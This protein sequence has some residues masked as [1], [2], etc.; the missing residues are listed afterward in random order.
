LIF[1]FL[2]EFV[3]QLI[4]FFGYGGIFLLMLLESTATPVA[5]ELV[6]PFAGFLAGQGKFSLE[7][8]VL[9]GAFGSLVGSLISY[10][11][12]AFLGKELLLHFGKYVFMEKK[13]LDLAHRWFDKHGDE[14]VFFARFVPV[15]RHL[16][17]FPAGFARMN[18]FKFS[19]YTF[20]GAFLWCLALAYAG[21]YLGE[22]WQVILSYTEILDVLIVAGVIAAA[23]FFIYAHWKRWKK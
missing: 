22:S 4:Q 19:A 10:F 16:I 13:E 11:I 7:L 2:F 5:S 15:V 14:V 20:G 1:E 9:A 3:L 12:G 8:V 17:S 21:I 6:M 23:C 18:L